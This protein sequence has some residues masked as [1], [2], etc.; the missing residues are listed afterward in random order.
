ME[1]LETP[2]LILR[3]WRV[4][5]ADDLYEYAKDSRV[6]PMAGWDIHKDVAESRRTIETVFARPDIF[7]IELKE[8]G[9][10][11]GSIGFIGRHRS[12]LPGP[13][14]ELGYALNPAYWGLGLMVEAL[15]AM[16]RC[17]FRDRGLET[18]WCGSCDK[19]AQTLR[20]IEKARFRYQLSRMEPVELVGEQCLIHYY[21]MNR[22]EW[23]HG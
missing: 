17:G 10:V 16:L 9:K 3:P 21:A 23:E 15:G 2:R 1:R 19:N 13:D 18:V 4:E 5:D 7:A 12:E 14:D 8:T 11:V 6:G 22:E 20:V